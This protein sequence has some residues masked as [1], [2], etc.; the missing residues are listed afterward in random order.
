MI[1]PLIRPMMAPVIRP[2]MMATGTP[3][4]GTS[5]KAM[6]AEKAA[7]APTDRSKLP[8]AMAS[9][10]PRPTIAMTAAL[11]STFIRLPAIKKLGVS[12]DRITP[13]ASTTTATL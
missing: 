8:D 10:I 6:Q 12:S 3:T 9:V 7:V 2:P 1:K 4:T 13:S 5:V 11:V